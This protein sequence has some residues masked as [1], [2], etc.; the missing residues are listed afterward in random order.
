MKFFILAGVASLSCVALAAACSSSSNKGSGGGGDGGSSGEG[1]GD[2]K[3]GDGGSS[4]GGTPYSGALA[5]AEA[6]AGVFDIA[7]SFIATPDAS[8]TANMCPGSGVMSGSCCYEPPAPASDAGAADAGTV[9][10]FSAGTI[11]I[12]DGTATLAN[13]SPGTNGAYGITSGA[14][15]P[16][17]KW[18]PG[19]TLA[20]SAAG[21]TVDA[22]TG[23]IVTVVDLA[24]ITPAL[25]LTTATNVPL[26]TPLVVS[27][28]A[29]TATTVR[30]TLLAAKGTAGDGLIS[31]SVNDS[32]GTVTVPTALLSKLT[33]GDNGVLSLTR[34]SVNMATGANVSVQLLSSTTS[35]GLVKFQ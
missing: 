28:T 1:G 18:T 25:S 8:A 12:K 4:S 5:A 14:M 33:T 13:M 2:A 24:G 32:A 26:A 19:D 30:V 15:N 7:G 34:Q 23:N 11:T 21:A 3:S 22:F 20:V 29:G 16:T 17:V 31:C 6:T 10:V 9:A 27:W 35:A